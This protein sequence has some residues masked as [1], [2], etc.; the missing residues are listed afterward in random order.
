MNRDVFCSINILT[1]TL[2]MS[3]S[4]F[5]DF[6]ASFRV[7]H[8][9]SPFKEAPTLKKMSNVNV[10][11]PLP[12]QLKVTDIKWLSVWCRRFTVNFAEVSFPNDL[13]VPKPEV[14]L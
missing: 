7:L 5:A 3:K 1:L 8:N 12:G 6:F 2:S 9:R 10:L 13:Q 11:L 4:L 14:S